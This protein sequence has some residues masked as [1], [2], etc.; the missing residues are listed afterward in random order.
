M[1][2]SNLYAMQEALIKEKYKEN[3]AGISKTNNVDLGVAYS[4]LISNFNCLKTGNIAEIKKGGGILSYI[5]LG[6]DLAQLDKYRR[7]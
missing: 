3:I 2:A 4:M 5:E 7:K 1:A 6:I